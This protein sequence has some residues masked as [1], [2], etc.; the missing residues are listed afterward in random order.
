LGP[1][2]GVVRSKEGMRIYLKAIT[3]TLVIVD[4]IL[5]VTVATVVPSSSAVNGCVFASVYS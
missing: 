4:I 1:A 2:I 3:S 5:H